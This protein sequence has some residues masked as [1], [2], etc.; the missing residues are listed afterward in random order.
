ML[1]SC[2]PEPDNTPNPDIKDEGTQEEDNNG[3][4]I[5]GRYICKISYDEIILFKFTEYGTGYYQIY[6]YDPVVGYT[7]ASP[8]SPISLVYN[9]DTVDAYDHYGSAATFKYNPFTNGLTDTL[10]D[11]TFYPID[12]SYNT[13]EWYKDLIGKWEATMEEGDI[14]ESIPTIIGTY[15]FTAGGYIIGEFYGSSGGAELM[16]SS[17]LSTVSGNDEEIHLGGQTLSYEV[18][19]DKKTL[20]LTPDTGLSLEPIVFTKVEDSLDS[21][22]F[23]GAYTSSVDDELA[24]LIRDGLFISPGSNVS[25][26][27]DITDDY[28]TLADGVMG[29]KI[30]LPYEYKNDTLT[31]EEVEA[32]KADVD[33]DVLSF[34]SKS[35]AFTN[36][37][38]SMDAS[39]L[40]DYF[41]DFDLREVNEDDE[42]IAYIEEIC[43]EVGIEPPA[44]YGANGYICEYKNSDGDFE[45]MHGTYEID[46]NT[47]TFT[48]HN[49]DEPIEVDYQL[50]FG[51]YA[52]KLLLSLNGDTRVFEEPMP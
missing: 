39:Y 42:W 25:A 26:I 49:G 10:N 15:E 33:F 6:E 36:F 30:K 29:I 1:I 13:P 20:T 4:S 35:M 9:E 18:S 31:I 48:P 51:N 5:V 41:I 23:S 27:I 11:N 52:A 24:V 3:K 45:F 38:E 22:P 46:E 8:V 21:I 17:L 19:E 14:E 37:Y 43:A 32:Q 28:L 7:N 2:K 34:L 12:S 16:M 40:E 47:I 50:S 44:V